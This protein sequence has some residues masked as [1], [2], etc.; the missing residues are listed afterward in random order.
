[1]LGAA[2]LRRCCRTDARKAGP[3]MATHLSLPSRT[4]LGTFPAPLQSADNRS[5]RPARGGRVRI[6]ADDY[7]EGGP[8]LV[9]ETSASTADFDRGEKQGAWE[10]DRSGWDGGAD[11]GQVA[12]FAMSRFPARARSYRPVPARHK[13]RGADRRLSYTLPS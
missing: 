4:A 7:I 13:R 12:I 1:M 5:I 6:R 3:G 8:E 10:S 9:A 2:C 11:I